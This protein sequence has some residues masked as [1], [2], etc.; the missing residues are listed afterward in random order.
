MLQKND[1]YCTNYTTPQMGDRYGMLAA[2]VDG[3]VVQVAEL[4]ECLLHAWYNDIKDDLA[5]IMFVLKE[6]RLLLR[7][8]KYYFLDCKFGPYSEQDGWVETVWNP[9]WEKVSAL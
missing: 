6:D 8:F 9:L 3:Q 5:K 2:V 1:G 4:T 7:A